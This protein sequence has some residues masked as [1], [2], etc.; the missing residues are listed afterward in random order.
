MF[1]SNCCSSTRVSSRE[2]FSFWWAAVKW[3]FSFS[4]FSRWLIYWDSFE[5]STLLPG[6]EKRSISF[7]YFRLDER[8]NFPFGQFANV[9]KMFIVVGELRLEQRFPI[10]NEFRRLVEQRRRI[11]RTNRSKRSRRS[12]E[13]RNRTKFLREKTIRFCF[14]RLN[15]TNILFFQPGSFGH[16]SSLWTKENNFDSRKKNV[17]SKRI[18][19]T[20]YSNE[21]WK[22]ALEKTS[23]V[24]HSS[25]GQT[26]IQ[27]NA[28]FRKSSFGSLS[29]PVETKS[30]FDFQ[31]FSTNEPNRS[32]TLNGFIHPRII[33]SFQ[34]ATNEFGSN[35]NIDLS[36]NP[37]A[38]LI[39]RFVFN[40]NRKV[41]LLFLSFSFRIDFNRRKI[42]FHFVISFKNYRKINIYSTT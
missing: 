29:L 1:L 13:C 3:F 28:T 21:N 33:S 17:R 35:G 34:S 19:F 41:E 23:F 37:L 27:R 15:K 39:V 31:N 30:S 10:V 38:N 25:F 12:L 26:K 36:T 11:E 40:S 5:W 16:L 22:N 20:L 6:R 8:D 24:T 7:C 42:D 4:F 32:E 9:V 14:V 2:T 18:D